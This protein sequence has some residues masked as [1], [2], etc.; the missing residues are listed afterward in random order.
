QNVWVCDSGTSS[1][2]TGNVELVFNREAL[3]K[4]QE[5]VRIGDGTVKKV[6]CVGTSNLDFHCDTD[7]GVQLSRVYVVDG[8]TI[9]FFSLHAVQAK[10]AVTLDSTGVHLLGGKIAFP[11][12]A[13]GSFLRATRLSPSYPVKTDAVATV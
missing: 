1:H 11:R 12:C 10:H 7:V 5:W 6:L 9:N 3:P 8:L 4:G 2:M 13:T